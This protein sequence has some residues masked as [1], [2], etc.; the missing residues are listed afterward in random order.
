MS[1]ETPSLPQ[2]GDLIG[3]RFRIL[4]VLGTGG[5]GTVYKA[6]QENIGRDVALKFLT[7]GVAKDPI[8]VER[9]RR[10]AFHV[11]QLRHP[12]TITLY[13]YGQ[14]EDE[15]AYMVMEYLD[16]ISLSD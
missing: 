10:E 6:L 15:L 7:P 2:P 3:G 12:N 9:F 14:T 1:S 11:S 16:G 5:F 13:D 4:E 8:N